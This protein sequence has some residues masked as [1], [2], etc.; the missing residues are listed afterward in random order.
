[1]TFDIHQPVFD[2]VS[3]EYLEEAAL[4]YREELETLFEASVEGK[5]LEDEGIQLGWVDRMM[6]LG[7]GYLEVTPARMSAAD[8]RTILFDLIPRKISAPADDAPGAIRELQLFWTFLQRE[9]HL[10]NAA[11]CLK[12]LKEKGTVQRMQEEMENPANF[13]MAKSLIM[14]GMQRGFDMTSQEGL[15]EW[16][17][18]YNAEMSAGTG[19]PIP[20]S[21]L[22]GMPAMSTQRGTSRRQTQ[23]GKANRKMAKSSRKQNRPKK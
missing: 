14:M 4:Q 16:V 5:T 11:A 3:G 17:A 22:F 1:M 20:P 10:E 23:A 2:K 6:D 12:V 18:T 13:G 8:L 9:F 7:I 15:N 21:S 19:T